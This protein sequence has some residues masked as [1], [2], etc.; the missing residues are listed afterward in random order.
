MSAA[1]LNGALAPTPFHRELAHRAWTDVLADWWPRLLSGIAADESHAVIATGQAVRALADADTPARRD[2]LATALARWVAHAQPLPGVVPPRG[3]L[4]AAGALAGVPRMIIQRGDLAERLARLGH[5][6]G[7][8]ASLTALRLTEPR[9]LLRDLVSAA[10]AR[11]AGHAHGAPIMLARAAIAPN[12]VLRVLPYLPRDQWAASAARAWALS[13]ALTAAYAPAAEA[14]ECPVPAASPDA[15]FAAALDN[16]DVPVLE[17]AGTAMDAYA[18]D[19]DK[20]ALVA[21]ARA[22]ELFF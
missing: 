4:T 6:P 8:P 15:A 16:G 18:R 3:R 20:R 2:A 19:G 17:L 14:D 10:L 21:V 13:A 1:V 12:A 11:Y 5:T 9:E 7:W 22:V